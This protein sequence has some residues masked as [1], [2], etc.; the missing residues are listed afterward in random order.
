M[1]MYGAFTLEDGAKNAETVAVGKPQDFVRK[2][3]CP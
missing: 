3:T 1:A 2:G